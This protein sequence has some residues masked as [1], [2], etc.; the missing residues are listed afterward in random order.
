VSILHA[1]CPE[2]AEFLRKE[3]IARF[4]QLEGKITMS[5]IGP[6]IGATCGPGIIALYFYGKKVEEGDE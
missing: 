4:P 6:I 2:D 5:W 3:V 1:I